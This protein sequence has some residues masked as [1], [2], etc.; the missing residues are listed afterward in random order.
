MLQPCCRPKMNLLTFK[1]QLLVKVCFKFHF[2]PEF[3]HFNVNIRQFRFK[4]G[5][6]FVFLQPLEIPKVFKETKL[7]NTSI[8]VT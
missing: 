6:C 7:G 8:N 4:T 5:R 2:N 1:N 3:C